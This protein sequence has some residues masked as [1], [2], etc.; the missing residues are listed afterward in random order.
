[1]TATERRTRSQDALGGGSAKPRVVLQIGHGKY[2]QIFAPQA[3]R[4]LAELADVTGPMAAGGDSARLAA[5]LREADALFVGGSVRVDRDLLEAAPRLRWIAATWGAPAQLIDYSE[6]FRRGITVTDGRRAFNR[7]VAELALGLYLAVARD[8]VMHD[9]ALHTPD[10]AEGMPKEAN[11]EASGRT[12]GIVGFGGISQTLARFLAPLEPRLLTYDPFV[13]ESVLA[14]HGAQPASLEDLLRRSDAVFLLA[15]PNAQ[16]KAL[17]GGAELDLLK[18]DSILLVISRSWLVDEAALIERL[19]AGRFRAAMDV[20]D[21]EPLPAGHPY[22]ALPNVVLTPHRAGGTQE[23]Y[24]RIGQAL[25]D[26]V[27]RL[28]HGQQP[29]HN[30]VIDTASARRQGLLT[31]V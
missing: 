13:P 5:L 16:N 3:R 15:R 21:T 18:P 6:V 10:G 14:A 28:A 7:A 19:Q 17:L 23:S 2:E 4:R 11:R 25:V 1:M 20:F 22:R 27:A 24:W 26:D 31:G 29:I 8:I 30:A 12:I 9:R